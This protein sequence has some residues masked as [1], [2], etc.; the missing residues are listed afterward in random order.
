MTGLLKITQV[1]L[2]RYE[3][4]DLIA[5]GGQAG[6]A[7]A[8]DRKTNKTVIVKKLAV[9]PG[10]ASYAEEVARFKRAA[11]IRISHPNAVDPIDYGEDRGEHY[12]IVPFIKGV[13]L[14]NHMSAKGG[15]LRSDEATRIV[16]GVAMG[17]GAI[18]QKNIV[19]RVRQT[20]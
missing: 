20:Y 16:T 18:H 14:E 9:F 19:H 13:T 1:V 6:I 10:G 5:E 4:I 11:Q 7:K 2:G 3:V 12:M 17:L 8:R 15:R